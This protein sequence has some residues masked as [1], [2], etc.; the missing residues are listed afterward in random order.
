SSET[1]IVTSNATLYIPGDF[2]INGSATIYIAQGGS[3]KLYLG[4]SDNKLNGGGISNLGGSATNFSMYGLNTATSIKYSGGAQ[5]IGSV[6]APRSDVTLTG[7]SDSY[8][9]IV[10]KSITTGGSMTF[11]YDEAL[12]GGNSKYIVTGWL[13]L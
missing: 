2:T 4:G 3:L 1:M 12:G 8:G 10:G 13:E 5:F 7:T 11:H 6:Y 9:A